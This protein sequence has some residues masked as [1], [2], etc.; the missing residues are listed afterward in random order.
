M[1]K[2]T[3]VLV[4]L[5]QADHILWFDTATRTFTLTHK[6]RP[7]IS[8]TLGTTISGFPLVR[9]EDKSCIVTWND[10]TLRLTEEEN[11]F[12]AEWV[13]NPGIVL[14]EHFSLASGGQ[15]FGGGELVRQGYPLETMQWEIA[16]Y[17]T[18]DNGPTGL[19]GVLHPV[20]YASSG[21]SIAV[22]P[23]CHFSVG[24]NAP[25]TPPPDR[26]WQMGI[27][28]DVPMSLPL[29]D[30]GD[31]D[32][33]FRLRVE[34]QAGEGARLA[35]TI[36]SHPTPVAAQ[37]AFLE[38]LPHPA[39]PPPHDM[40]RD[41]IWTTWARFK[42]GIDQ[43]WTLKF[44][45]EIIAHDFPHSIM[46]IDDKWSR[47][48]GDMIFDP[49]KFPDPKEMVRQLHD[50]GFRVTLWVTPFAAE[51]SH[52]FIEGL[53]QGFWVAG[54]SGEAEP[55]RWWQGEGYALD[56]TN[57]R[58]VAW[59]LDRLYQLREKYGIDGF[60][61]D[62]GESCFLPPNF[63]CHQPI[64]P[65]DYTHLWVERVAG[66]FEWAEVRSAYR[67][68]S[69]SLFVREWDRHSSWGLD[70]GLQSVITA[71]LTFG[72]LGYPFVLPDMVGG[73]AYGSLLPDKELLIR[74]A[75]ANAL[76]PAMQF[77]IA[78]WD[79]DEETIELCRKA[80]KWHTDNAQI[81]PLAEAATQTGHP[82]IRPI[83][84]LAPDDPTT[85][86]I[87]SQ[88]ALGESTMVAPVMEAGA[89]SRDFYLPAGTW[90][91]VLRETTL[92]GGRWYKDYPAPLDYLP[93]FERT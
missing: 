52:A 33:L 37:Q 70:N 29:P 89:R 66:R 91:D 48:Y 73:N 22:E 23:D 38:S 27:N 24:F 46:E 55:I 50:K 63:Q 90:R 14:E 44:A 30:T 43:H 8:G 36:H 13:G 69:A 42:M 2:S 17:Q 61:F 4:S 77:S 32:G 34:P 1:D 67:N 26:L 93:W 65:N 83:S 20:W 78:P 74:W 3:A 51:H 19:G 72:L 7:V 21:I 71:A 49:I 10:A 85:Y 47:S 88:F 18:W 87:G 68:Q 35:Y 92:E 60:K 82:I 62:A 12:R 16:P 39:S 76:L 64:L 40:F 59:Y 84:W 79:F 5:T 57:D 6:N 15:W 56:V 58:A 80:V 25:R 45:D 28:M 11:G 54:K 75:Q 86:P 53:A 31:G 9:W 41:P 81:F